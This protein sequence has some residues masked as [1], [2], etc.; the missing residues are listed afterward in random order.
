MTKTLP[1]KK[2]F[3][4]FAALLV[5]LTFAV[6]GIAA[7]ALA[8][9]STVTTEAVST[10]TTTFDE[11]LGSWTTTSDSDTT[12]SSGSAY[13]VTHVKD[14]KESDNA[15][16]LDE[17]LGTEGFAIVQTSTDPKFS[18]KIE[19]A[20]GFT[21]P[22]FTLDRDSFYKISVAVAAKSDS[23]FGGAVIKVNGFENPL[24]YLDA[25]HNRYLTGG[26]DTKTLYV[27]TSRLEEVSATISL[28]LG[29]TDGEKSSG[30]A[31]FDSVY[32]GKVNEAEF[33]AAQNTAK[34]TTADYRE[35]STVATEF[36]SGYSVKS[37]DFEG[38]NVYAEVKSEQGPSANTDNK[39]LTI[40]NL[41]SADNGYGSVKL[42]ALSFN[43]LTSAEDGFMIL[44][45][46][47]K[48]IDF[49]GTASATLYYR[50]VEAT[51][52]NEQQISSII[53]DGNVSRNGW[54]LNRL[55]VKTSVVY[56]YTGY[57]SI[58][59]G[60]ES[61]PASGTVMI[62][63]LEITPLNLGDY[64]AYSSAITDNASTC[65][66]DA[67]LDD[68]TG[69]NGSFY[70]LATDGDDKTVL[71]PQ[72]WGI[73][74]DGYTADYELV[75]KA[76][77]GLDFNKSE[78]VLDDY[79]PIGNVVKIASATP[80]VYGIESAAIAVAAAEENATA[81]NQISVVAGG[82]N[83]TG[84][85]A[86]ISIVDVNGNVYGIFEKISATPTLY[87]FNVKSKEA[88]D[89]FVRLT[90]GY[91][92]YGA[93]APATGELY[94]ARVDYKS[95]TEAVYAQTSNSTKQINFAYASFND[96]TIYD[97]SDSNDV[98]NTQDYLATL[99]NNGNGSAAHGIVDLTGLGANNL[100]S[101]ATKGDPDVLPY[102]G[103][104]KT[105]GFVVTDANAV[106]TFKKNFSMT[107]NK[108]EESSEV[109]D[110]YYKVKVAVRAYANGP[111]T[112][113]LMNAAS[114]DVLAKI[115]NI[116]DTK[117]YNE[118][119]QVIKDQFVVYEFFVKLDDADITANLFVKFGGEKN[120]QKAS[121]F[122]LIDSYD[123]VSA[124]STEYT[125][126]EEA[127]KE[128]ETTKFV[129][130]LGKDD[131]ENEK[132][133]TVDTTYSSNEDWFLVPSILF[134]A[135][136]VLAIVGAYLK[137]WI[138]ARQAK[139][140]EEN[141]KKATNAPKGYTK[142]IDYSKLKDEEE[143][144]SEEETQE[145]ETTATGA[146][147]EAFDEDA[148]Y[149]EEEMYQVVEARAPEAPAEEATEQAEE[150]ADEQPEQPAEQ[151]EETATAPEQA[152]EPKK[153]EPAAPAKPSDSEFDD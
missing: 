66:F 124:V 37:D 11:S 10:V 151:A 144:V 49:E 48:A 79:N 64:V 77:T 43:Q 6:A 72:S 89:L 3:V 87:T 56:D 13:T 145:T 104:T 137:K 82:K 8:S 97:A 107:L 129:V 5:A 54:T 30:Y 38:K 15:F 33:V 148:E 22:S 106:L 105:Y 96:Y 2:H 108:D 32:V 93:T 20:A 113:G 118:E 29:D 136:L 117:K 121:G 81:Y 127:I 1:V 73:K 61:A 24:Y 114:G 53:A 14:F 76:S 98:K 147:L 110:T 152:E 143:T 63:R 140:L 123:V 134:A 34:V 84:A 94:V 16:A 59:Y 133:D 149:T 41:S 7:P 65:D 95:I 153:Q 115:E 42:P 139:K 135:A 112:I 55:F 40:H 36:E 103:K 122:A 128:G 120:S 62:D 116:T 71:R 21:S 4:A 141:K 45:F 99:V 44:S 91:D 47:S 18:D 85:G 132:D 111:L 31:A 126:A 150:T 50:S 19:I 80:T 130:N 23:D 17:T 78:F 12:L 100:L 74:A 83:L 67:S 26:W 142:R 35:T 75:S 57:V 60:S 58:N 138:T 39:V 68:K 146:E 131:K 119:N 70:K 27:A 92:A 46:Y 51:K 25:N 109:L 102:L 90:L 28:T 88:V 52:Y 69:I 101:A 86:T 125:D 9:E